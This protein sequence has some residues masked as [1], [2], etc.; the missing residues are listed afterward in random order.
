MG[1][2]LFL[3]MIEVMQVGQEGL[4]LYFSSLWNYV[5]LGSFGLQVSQYWLIIVPWFMY[6]ITISPAGKSGI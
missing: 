5:D 4:V 2:C 6:S 3:F 1:S